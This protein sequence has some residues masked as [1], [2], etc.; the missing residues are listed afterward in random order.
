M[1]LRRYKSILAAAG[2]AL[3]LS[4]AALACNVPVFRF[5]LERWRADAYRVVVFH[6]GPLSDADR[7]LIRPLEE[8]QDRLTANL[9]V[10]TVDVNELDSAASEEAAL[11]RQFLSLLTNPQFPCLAVQYPAHLRIE[12]PVWLSPLSQDGVARLTDSPARKELIKR[13][14][15]GQT[16]VWILLESGD[17]AKDAEVEGLLVR[18][19]KSLE[20]TLELPEL[21]ASPD[22]ALATQLPLEVKFSVLRVN[23][24]DEAEQALA[25]MLIY[26]EPDLAERSDP[27]VFPVFGRGRALLPLIGAGITEQNIHDAAEFLAGPCSCEVKEQNP[28][29]DLLLNGDWDMLLSPTG[30][31]LTTAV[32]A[33]KVPAEAELVPIPK[34]SSA[35]AAPVAATSNPVVAPPATITVFRMP[36]ILVVGGVAFAALL[37]IV[38]VVATTSSHRPEGG[39]P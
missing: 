12:K 30:A 3:A 27:M 36:G 16:A 17:V 25:A 38:I 28:G 33:N 24:S 31:P 11:D 26:S 19:L 10:R 37:A 35:A 6:K 1:K 4:A 18:Q 8:H 23:K 13:L 32:T 2:L 14:A 5:A 39:T 21:T 29:F 22:D 7:E 20:E 15:E 9:L 34:G